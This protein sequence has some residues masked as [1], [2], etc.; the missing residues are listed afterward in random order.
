VIIGDAG[1][2]SGSNPGAVGEVKISWS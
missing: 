1:S 2:W